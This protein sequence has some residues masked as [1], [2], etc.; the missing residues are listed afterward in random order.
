MNSETGSVELSFVELYNKT[1]GE[2][3]CLNEENRATAI[4]ASQK[5][6]HEGA[7]PQQN[8]LFNQEQKR[9]SLLFS[10]ISIRLTASSSTRKLSG[11]YLRGVL[12]AD[13]GNIV[14][15]HDGVR[16][17]GMHQVSCDYST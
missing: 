17:C 12:T 15:T 14:D 1:D 11:K 2:K 4:V 6:D 5:G 10:S 3:Y 16:D 9:L 7:L 13:H 8:T